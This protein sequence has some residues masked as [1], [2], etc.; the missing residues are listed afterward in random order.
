MSVRY[1]HRELCT[2]YARL[3][4][5]PILSLLPSMSIESQRAPRKCYRPQVIAIHHDSSIGD[6]RPAEN[7]SRRSSR[8]TPAGDNQKQAKTLPLTITGSGPRIR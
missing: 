5:G 2:A 6:G 1:M 3:R 4:K 8:C 7:A